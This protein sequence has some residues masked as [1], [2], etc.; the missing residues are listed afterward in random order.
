CPENATFYSATFTDD[1]GN[2]FDIPN[3]VCVFEE[4]EY[5]SYHHADIFQGYAEIAR[6]SRNIVFRYTTIV[7]NYDYFFDWKFGEDGSINLR[8]GA[9]GPL[10]TKGL[11]EHNVNQ[12][13]GDDLAWG[14]LVDDRIGGPNHQHIFSVRLDMD[15][16]GTK[17]SLVQLTPNVVHVSKPDS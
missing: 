2:P 4:K 16:D 5:L 1:Y 12:A 15:V 14:S 10:E 9:S 6:T 8:V 7:G 17:N 11:P 13:H 3:A